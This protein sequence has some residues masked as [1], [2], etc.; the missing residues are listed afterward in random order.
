[1]SS[2]PKEVHISEKISL[3]E[4]TKTLLNTIT[5]IKRK[6]RPDDFT[7][8]TVSQT[9][10]FLALVYEKV[11]N[12]IEYREEHLI[13]RAAIERILKR[14]L[15]MNP[16]ADGE[17]EN[18]LR[19]LMWAR[20]FPNGSL[21]EHDI[22]QIQTIINT[23]L[24]LKKNLLAGRNHQEKAFLSQFLFD[25]LTCEIE[26]KLSPD[27]SAEET[28][29]TYFLYQ[30]LKD[31]VKIEELSEAQ[32]DAFLFIAI[33]KAY[34]KSDLPYQRYH[35]FNL[36]YQPIAQYSES[37]LHELSSKL[38]T[39]FRK[40]EDMILNPTTEKLVKFTRKQLPPFLILFELIRN[41]RK[42]AVEILQNQDTLWSEVD[43]LCRTKYQQ[44]KSRLNILAFKSLVYIFV[45]KML[46][47]IILEVPVSRL[48]F[49]EVH[50]MSIAVNSI[51]PPILMLLIV[52]SIRLPDEENTK[53][54]FQRITDIINA[55]QTFEKTIAFIT[56]KTKP[57][58][59]TLVFGFTI[60]YLFTFIVTLV[61]INDILSFLNF[62][63][64]SKM[65]FVFFISVVSFFSYRIKNVA[66]EYRLVERE[67]ILRP[68]VDFFFMPILSLGKIFSNGL[69]SINIF[70]LL[71]DFIIEAPFKLIIEVIEEWIKFVRARKE[72]II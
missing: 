54:I 56:K 59:P 12:A 55:D 46:F 15:G 51:A 63:I 33:E 62:N 49:G 21:D 4:L 41:K 2:D 26:E 48:I 29:F 14:R 32:K 16:K 72:E 68:L 25:L 31:K 52:L 10:T 30:T 67:S 45:T 24:Q 44:I 18:L 37:E 1:M 70:I 57:K 61:L 66:N 39:I 22:Q 9:V 40:I 64:L 42:Q 47:A 58:R 5:S 38:P 34:R 3:S 60:L 11:R 6:A 23:Y 43:L 71:F 27:S 50:L 53:R 13:R 69:S 35:L 36:F 17:A 8:L 19:E 65:L 7:K 28:N 20:Y